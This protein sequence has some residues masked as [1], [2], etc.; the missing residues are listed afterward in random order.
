[1]ELVEV[2]GAKPQGVVAGDQRLVV[3]FAVE[4]ELPVR[5][6]NG[7]VGDH[8]GQKVCG[9]V[10]EIGGLPLDVH[11]GNLSAGEVEGGE[12]LDEVFEEPMHQRFVD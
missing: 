5:P 1:M 9:G 12:V 8:A 7:D 6:C 10:G 3:V 4:D 11:G 2:A